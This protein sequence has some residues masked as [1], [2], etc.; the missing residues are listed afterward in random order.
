MTLAD[1]RV[2]LRAYLLGESAISTAVG[3]SRIYALR[4][5]QGQVQDSIVYSRI[6]GIGDHTMQGATGLARP[7]VQIDCWSADLD[8][9]NALANLVKQRIDGF[10]GSI[11]WGENSPSE[12]IV[13]QGIFFDSEREDY[14]DTAKLYRVSRD[15]LI[16]FGER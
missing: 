9:A 4:L 2:G 15:F 6:S 16:W 5:P 7:R 1:I 8:R 3:G 13:V 11:L 14:D 10:R 12:A